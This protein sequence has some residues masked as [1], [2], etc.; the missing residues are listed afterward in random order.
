[1]LNEFLII[2]LGSVMCLCAGTSSIAKSCKC[3]IQR[4][5]R[6][7][8]GLPQGVF[9]P[10]SE[11]ERQGHIPTLR[12]QFFRLHVLLTEGPSLLSPAK[13]GADCLYL[14]KTKP[15]LPSCTEWGHLRGFCQGKPAGW[16]SL[17]LTSPTVSHRKDCVPMHA[18]PKST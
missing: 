8:G 13:E 15:R 1:M 3:P 4:R 10:G 2:A 16:Y 5:D 14:S 9:C 7:P 12:C 17:T 18:D 11:D 6:A